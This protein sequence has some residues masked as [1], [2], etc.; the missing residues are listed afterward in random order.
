MQTLYLPTGCNGAG[1]TT[2]AF[3]LLPGCWK[4]ATTFRNRS[5]GGGT[6][7]ACTSFLVLT[8]P[9]STAGRLWIIRKVRRV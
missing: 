2:A 4:A 5:S 7:V 1:K 8:A 9:S 3:T 6:R